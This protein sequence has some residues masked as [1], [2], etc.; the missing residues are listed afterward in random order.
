MEI[1]LRFEVYCFPALCPESLL[2]KGSARTSFALW[3][4]EAELMWHHLESLPRK[5]CDNKLI[6]KKYVSLKQAFARNPK[7]NYACFMMEFFFNMIQS[8]SFEKAGI[9]LLVFLHSPC[10][11]KATWFTLSCFESGWGYFPVK[12]RHAC[13]F[14]KQATTNTA[15]SFF[16]APFSLPGPL[17]LLLFLSLS[18][19]PFHCVCC[20][21]EV[22]MQS[23]LSL[24]TET[25]WLRIQASHH[26]KQM[27]TDR[28]TES[29]LY[30]FFQ[31]SPTLLLL[32]LKLV[33]LAIS[34]PPLSQ[35]LP[36]LPPSLPASPL[37]LPPL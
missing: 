17:S 2:L 24:P 8:W 23:R 18:L 12:L 3:A 31:L 37:I 9:Y 33:S 21:M 25:V 35:L 34:F 22:L 15:K 19:S 32:L 26:S 36:S 5:L 6:A 11:A 4:R 27:T 28:Y 14:P 20:F 7:K 10:V 29:C 1:V 13:L 16:F 30:I